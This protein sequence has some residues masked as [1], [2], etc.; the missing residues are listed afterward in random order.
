MSNKERTVRFRT[1]AI[2]AGAV[3]LRQFA[4]MR[5]KHATVMKSRAGPVK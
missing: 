2:W 1:L 3:I 5:A 4:K